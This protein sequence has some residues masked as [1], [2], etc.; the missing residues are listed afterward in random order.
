MNFEFDIDDVI[1][2]EITIYDTY[3]NILNLEYDK[4]LSR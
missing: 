1:P 4:P 3:L 2:Y